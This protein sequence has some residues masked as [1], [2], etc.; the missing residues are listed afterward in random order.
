M[1]ERFEQEF[2]KDP[3]HRVLPLGPGGIQPYVRPDHGRPGAADLWRLGAS[4]GR[5]LGL[6]AAFGRG[7]VMGMARRAALGSGVA[8]QHAPG[9]AADAVRP[10]RAAPQPLR[11]AA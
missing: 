3:W 8:R 11:K 10:A 9:A 2:Y 1:I 6:I 5:A 4:I 7:A